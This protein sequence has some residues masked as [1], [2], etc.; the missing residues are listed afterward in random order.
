MS[1]DPMADDEQPEID[2]EEVS[3]IVRK[4]IKTT[5]DLSEAG[6]SAGITLEELLRRVRRIEEYLGIGA[7]EEAEA[8]DYPSGQPPRRS[9]KQHPIV[10]T[11]GSD[12]SGPT[13][14]SSTLA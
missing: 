2:D 5:G 12:E 1:S 7:H 4:P 11:P 8:F 13:G 6:D 14:T 10:R 9:G 3:E